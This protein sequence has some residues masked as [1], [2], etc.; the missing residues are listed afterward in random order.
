MRTSL[1]ATAFVVLAAACA[2]GTDEPGGGA[3]YLPS[4]GIVPVTVPAEPGVLEVEDV[5]LSRPWGLMAGADVMQVWFAAATDEGSSI[6]LASGALVD[7]AWTLTLDTQTALAASQP[8]EGTSLTHPAVVRRAD[9]S[10][11]MAYVAGDGHIGLATATGD[12]W[13]AAAE[14]IIEGS[15]DEPLTHPS[16]IDEP[17]LSRVLLFYVR[18]GAVHLAIG[19]AAGTKFD[20]QETAVL[21][22]DEENALT[23]ASVIRTSSTLGRTLYR[24]HFANALGIHF[25]GGFEPT[26][27]DAPDLNPVMEDTG[28]KPDDP[29]QAGAVILYARNLVKNKPKKGRGLAVAYIG[30]APPEPVEA[31]TPL[32]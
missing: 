32:Q 12:T 7:G 25:A 28:F 19:N 8:W 14:P 10:L 4:S 1:S 24:C 2:T 11:L 23:A 16:L 15:A 18:A 20:V 21:P 26:A 13:T 5:D 6:G 9:G 27:L 3:D 30:E 29:M 22:A 31:D 17:A